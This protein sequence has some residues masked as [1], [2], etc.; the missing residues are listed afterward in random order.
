MKITKNNIIQESNKHWHYFIKL[1]TIK[2][3]ITGKYLFFSSSFEELKKVVIEELVNNNFSIAKINTNKN[4]VGNNYVL[5]LY[6]L[7]DS[8]KYEL[9]NK[10]KKNKNIKY[11]Y[12]K[13]DEDTTNNKYSKEFLNKIKK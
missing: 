12:W 6:F 7:N 3:K 9:A 1:Q 8:R 2:P 5:C 10:Y 4:K 11:R 13:N